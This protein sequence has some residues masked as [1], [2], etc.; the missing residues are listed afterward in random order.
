MPPSISL[1]DQYME[2]LLAG[3]RRQCRNLIARQLRQRRTA[4]RL[5][6]NIVWRS[7]E[8][9]DCLYRENHI[10]AAT[11]HMAVRINRCMST[12][13]QMSLQQLPHNRRRTLITCAEGELEEVGGQMLADLFETRG[14]EVYFLGGGV[15]HDEVLTLVGQLRPEIL[16]VCGTKPQDAPDVRALIDLIRE[17]GANPTMNVLVTGGVFNRANGLWKEVNADLFAET[18]EKAIHLAETA[19]PRKPDIRIP[20]APKKRRR[21][22]ASTYLAKADPG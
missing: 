9:V 2:P 22:R 10:N 6:H 20:G 17:V 16:L 1:L 12:Q 5:L 13:L 7:M 21:R 18:P 14:W 3:D 11:E 15:P 19:T 4:D 8:R